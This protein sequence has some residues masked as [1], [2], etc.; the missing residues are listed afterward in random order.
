MGTPLVRMEGREGRGGMLRQTAPPR[1]A[2]PALDR[3]PIRYDC[4]V[5]KRK[6]YRF[7]WCA[8]PRVVEGFKTIRLPPIVDAAIHGT[9]ICH[10]FCIAFNCHHSP[11]L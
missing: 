5:H 3:F 1:A 6:A 8:E 7:P 11:R 10:A 4:T 9:K 2:P